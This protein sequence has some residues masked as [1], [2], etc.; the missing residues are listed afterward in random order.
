[1]KIL[2]VEDDKSTG[3]LLQ[4]I[5]VKMGY[6]TGLLFSAEEALEKINDFAIFLIDI[7]LPDMNGI[8]LCL[9]IKEKNPHDSYVIIVTAQ[10]D[11]TIL[12]SVLNAGADDFVAKPITKDLLKTRLQIAGRN[13]LLN[14]EKTSFQNEL[15]KNEEHLKQMLRQLASANKELENFARVVSHDLKAPLRTM[16]SL[17]LW[18]KEDY[19]EKLDE[20]GQ[21]YIKEIQNKTTKMHDLIDGIL[22]YSKKGLIEKNINPK[23]Y[24]TSVK[25]VIDEV[26]SLLSVSENIEIIHETD[27]PVI[28][29]EKTKVE[30]IYLNLFNKALSVNDSRVSIKTGVQEEGNFQKFYIS[31]EY[32]NKPEEK[33]FKENP[34]LQ[35]VFKMNLDNDYIIVKNIISSFGGKLWYDTAKKDEF[36]FYFTLPKEIKRMALYG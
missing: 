23:V 16:H 14:A 19:I 34:E 25:E 10:N 1:M 20:K 35:T 24:Q 36:T 9:K 7:G 3:K 28:A 12:T 32:K 26:T 6:N 5:L 29:Y 13:I 8:E 30:Q 17:A 4:D 2:I 27:L 18:L 33:V 31:Y 22:D 21:K 15:E 11:D